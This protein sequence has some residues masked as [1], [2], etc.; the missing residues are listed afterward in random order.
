M[1]TSTDFA[2]LVSFQYSSHRIRGL[3]RSEN[4]GHFCMSKMSSVFWTGQ[5]TNSM[6]RI[7]KANQMSKAC[8][9]SHEYVR[10]VK[11][12]LSKRSILQVLFVKNEN[13]I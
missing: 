10:Q 6:A 13:T 1:R 3:A 8:A 11:I 12:K 7:Y 5:S 9:S 2:H 4:A